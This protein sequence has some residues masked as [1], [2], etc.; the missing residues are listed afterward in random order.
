MSI[1]KFLEKR[2][3]KIS[4][5]K[6]F[7]QISS[8]MEKEKPV[9]T[10]GDSLNEMPLTKE[11]T[12]NFYPYTGNEFEKVVHT[13]SFVI[14]WQHF[15]RGSCCDIYDKKDINETTISKDNNKIPAIIRYGDQ[16]NQI[17]VGGVGDISIENKEKLSDL[18]SEVDSLFNKKKELKNKTKKSLFSKFK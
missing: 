12:K 7:D 1:K 4:L 8:I 5:N 17:S 2:K 3:E 13:K 6:M 10:E 11:F 15:I 9:M 18:I 14:Q 16:T